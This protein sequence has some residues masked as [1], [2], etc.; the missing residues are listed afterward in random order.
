MIT[1][2]FAIGTSRLHRLDPR[3]R[4]ASAAAFSVA[5]ALCQGFPALFAALALSAALAAAARLPIRAVL[6]RLALVNGLVFFLWVAIPFT[7]PGE[8]VFGL[9][10]LQ[11]SREG[12]DLAAR[13]TLKSNAIVL[14]LIALVA[15]MPVATAGQALSRLRVP[16]KLVF[17]LLMTYRYIFVLEQ[18]YQRLVRSARIRGFRP[19]TNLHTYRTFAYLVGML[20]VRAAERGER[21]H[22]AM[23]CRGFK[24]RFYSLQEFKAD[25][26]GTAFAVLMAAAVLAIA[27][28]EMRSGPG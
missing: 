2:P 18:E 23:V 9:W 25:F 12:V 8:P 13:I 3:I 20:F 7:F 6:R 22:W 28:L 19:A 26:A 27:V 5:A 10:G 16:G 21:V 17:L 15:T 14:S 11:A 24:R 1:E 4:L